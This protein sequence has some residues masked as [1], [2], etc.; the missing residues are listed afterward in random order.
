MRAVRKGQHIQLTDPQIAKYNEQLTTL[1][2]TIQAEV[3]LLVEDELIGAIEAAVPMITRLLQLVAKM[4][5]L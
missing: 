5:V 1:L 4:D 2:Q 3:R